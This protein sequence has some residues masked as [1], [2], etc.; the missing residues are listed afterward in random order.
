MVFVEARILPPREMEDT[1]LVLGEGSYD[2]MLQEEC[3][4]L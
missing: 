3:L 1:Y 2:V 4:V